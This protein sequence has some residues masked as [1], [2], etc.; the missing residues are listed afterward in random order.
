MQSS[1][2][3]GSGFSRT[4]G[5][6][7]SESILLR[8]SKCGEAIS[9]SRVLI[10]EWNDAWVIHAIIIAEAAELQRAKTERRSVTTVVERVTWIGSTKP[11]R[12]DQIAIHVK[13]GD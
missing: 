4:Q 11:V 1:R 13:S 6:I 7:Q 3:A 9:R 10:A 12:S 8:Q 2:K 5:E